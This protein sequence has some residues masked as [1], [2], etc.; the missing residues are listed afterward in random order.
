MDL[1]VTKKNIKKNNRCIEKATYNESQYFF[2]GQKLCVKRQE[3]AESEH[4]PTLPRESF[5]TKNGDKYAL[6]Y[7]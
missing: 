4:W 5:P 7:S 2:Q 1:L 6:V 3:K